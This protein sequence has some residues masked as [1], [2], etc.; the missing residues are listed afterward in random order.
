MEKGTAAIQSEESM[1]I[2]RQYAV[3]PVPLKG[4]GLVA[5]SKIRKGTRILAEAPIV[6]VPRD[7]SDLQALSDIIVKQLRTLS[8][9][10]QRA[11]LTTQCPRKAP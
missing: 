10:Q 9:E 4:Q 6:K 7:T 2:S 3:R 5:I 11:F 1:S 8:K